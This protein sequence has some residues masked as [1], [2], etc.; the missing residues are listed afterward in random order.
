M[1]DESENLVIKGAKGTEQI[2][3]EVYVNSSMIPPVP[4]SLK[5]NGRNF[6][7]WGQI[8][9]LTLSLKG[10]ED[11]LEKEMNSSDPGY[12]KWK[13][14]DMLALIYI[15][16]SMKNDQLPKVKYMKTAFQVWSYLKKSAPKKST[17]Y[18]SC[19]LTHRIWTTQQGGRPV[20]EYYEEI[21]ALWAELDHLS[22]V[23]NE[24]VWEYTNKERLFKFLLGLKPEYNT[25]RSQILNREK[26][27]SLEE[28]FYIVLDEE[29]LRG[30]DSE[31]KTEDGAGLLT[32][33]RVQ[34]ERNQ[35]EVKGPVYK[36]NQG[37]KSDWK[38]PRRPNIECNYCGK[39]GHVEDTC[40]TKHGKPRGD[41]AYNVQVDNCPQEDQKAK[42]EKEKG[43]NDLLKA[44][45]KEILEEL[46]GH[47]SFS[48][49]AT[50]NSGK[51]STY[52]SSVR[53][54][55]IVDSGATDHM[56]PDIRKF[57]EYISCP[58]RK[59]VFTAGGEVLPVAG[60]GTVKFRD[61]GFMKNVLHVPNLKAQ[62]ISPQRLAKDIKYIFDITDD[63]CFLIE[64]G[65]RRRILAS[66]ER[67]GLLYLEDDDHKAMTT[68]VLEMSKE[69]C[70]RSEELRRWHCR[71]GHPSFEFL[72]KLFPNL[73]AKIVRNQFKCETCELAKHKR[74]SFSGKS[75]RKE[76][77]F[78]LIHSD[79]WGPSAN[80][81]ITG[82]R[83]FLILVDDCTRATWIYPLKTKGEVSQR[84][85]EFFAMVER[86]FNTL[87]KC[88]RSDNARD[89]FNETLSTFFRTKGVIH[90]SSC[91]RTPE[92]NGVAERKIGYIVEM[93]RALMIHNKVPSYLWSEA[94]H[95]AV[96]LIN[97]LPSKAL[98]DR[99]P[100]DLMCE[101]YPTLSLRMGLTPKIFG[102]TVFVHEDN[103]KDKF[104]PRAIKC[105][106][107]GYSPTQKGYKCYP[108]P[109]RKFYVSASVTFHEDDRY[110]KEASKVI[111]T[112]RNE[113]KYTSTGDNW[114]TMY[115]LEPIEEDLI[116]NREDE[117]EHESDDLRE[118][119]G[120][121][122]TP[123]VETEDIL[124]Q[125]EN[126]KS[127]EQRTD[128]VDTPQEAIEGLQPSDEIRDANDNGWPISLRK[129]K[130]SCTQKKDYPWASYANYRCVSKGYKAFLTAIE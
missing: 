127:H 119:T 72:V 103:P 17:T 79:V 38:V 88:F 124:S 101:R 104:S 81:S 8:V 33:S 36:R 106:F 7:E 2:S 130:R 18:R 89:F 63:G 56:T 128:Q 96:H 67:G 107:V 64:K 42:E 43:N 97:R 65:S 13:K 62:L 26:V 121:E 35:G 34:R 59:K 99:S 58:G 11:H 76:N 31:G 9:E 77:P 126:E 50:S 22:P 52:L 16:T 51:S 92:Q 23:K 68:G 98:G 86:Q 46:K 14:D 29:S 19:E 71:L 66:E 5:L 57:K 118:G 21:Q 129:G 25:L 84:V 110:Y 27:P 112:T 24:S 120:G 60:I 123:E 12:I 100:L 116:E 122:A 83:W 47:I 78:Q 30:L 87:I 91:V 41:K 28:A 44:L 6:E 75:E 80:L 1:S 45:K 53:S 115:D 117:E 4:E 32:K 70:R 15:K 54:D 73:G 40:W 82:D 20:S 74:A 10:L 114:T 37:D 48:S 108:P 39:K 102:C 111:S 3:E 85:K 109:S 105:V 113:D 69:N 90:Q 125:G 61:M 94:V 49:L 95:T 93:A 55:W